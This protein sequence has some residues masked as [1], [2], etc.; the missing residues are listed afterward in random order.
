MFK[1]D[2][3]RYVDAHGHP[4]D[5]IV[6]I[7]DGAGRAP[8]ADDFLLPIVAAMEMAVY[9]AEDPEGP[10]FV[11]A[12][13]LHANLDVRRVLLTHPEQ[14]LEAS[15]SQF[16]VARTL[17]CLDAFLQGT[18]RKVRVITD[19]KTA[20]LFGRKHKFGAIDTRLIARTGD[21]RSAMG[22]RG[23][24]PFVAQ[25]QQQQAH[26]FVFEVA[27]PL[28]TGNVNPEIGRAFAPGEVRVDCILCLYSWIYLDLPLS[29]FTP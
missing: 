14:M 24:V 26:N 17:P 22:L 2:E 5:L 7:G 1:D 3:G 16:S 25:Q 18:D 11:V 27:P 23:A 8:L 19:A 4:L 29:D 15:S 9:G 21:L 12:G 28:P 20:E 13:S 10:H 6:A